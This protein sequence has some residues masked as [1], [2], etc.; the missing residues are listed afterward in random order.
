MSQN[1]SSIDILQVHALNPILRNWS[2]PGPKGKAKQKPSKHEICVV[3]QNMWYR[4]VVNVVWLRGK[5]GMVR[6][7]V[8]F[9]LR[10]RLSPLLK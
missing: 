6:G 2:E 3:T 8:V 7:A 4:H 9:W 10:L 1:T 5:W